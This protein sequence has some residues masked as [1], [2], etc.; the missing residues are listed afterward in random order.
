MAE[1]K[2]PKTRTTPTEKKPAAT[3]SGSGN[4]LTQDIPG[5]PL[6][7]APDA[8]AAGRA[9]GNKIGH[10]QSRFGTSAEEVSI[11]QHLQERRKNPRMP[12][13]APPAGPPPSFKDYEPIVGRAELDEI[14][15]I[16]KYLKGKSGK[17]VNYTALG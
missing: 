6:S 5:E 13:I 10:S 14:R 9:S 1:K 7:Q 11:P 2:S 8:A 12:T 16:A 15:F 3:A 4:S 17:M